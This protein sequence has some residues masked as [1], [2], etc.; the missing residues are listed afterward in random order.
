ML[1][2]SRNNY[3]SLSR[4]IKENIPNF[5][6]LYHAY[7]QGLGHQ[8]MDKSQNRHNNISLLFCL[9]SFWNKQ[10]IMNKII[11]RLWLRQIPPKYN[12]YYTKFDFQLVNVFLS[13][14]SFISSSSFPN[15]VIR[16]ISISVGHWVKLIQRSVSIS[17]TITVRKNI[18][19][20]IIPDINIWILLFIVRIQYNII[21]VI[22]FFS[23][24]IIFTPSLILYLFLAVW[25]S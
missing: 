24:F 9:M 15:S 14:V 10:N 5:Y 12:K 6:L 16:R 11:N 18:N 23:I 7:I 4:S 25:L 22:M 2:E 1:S 19:R 20:L 17:K 13:G 3:W 8:W 21:I